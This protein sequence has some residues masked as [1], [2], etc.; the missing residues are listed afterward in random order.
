M[1]T[2]SPTPLLLILRGP[3]LN[4]AEPAASRAHSTAELHPHQVSLCAPQV[5]TL[6]RLRPQELEGT[7]LKAT[8]PTVLGVT[9]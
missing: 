3:T 7:A 4:G 9:V 6:T 1:G 8:Q 2:L 5:P